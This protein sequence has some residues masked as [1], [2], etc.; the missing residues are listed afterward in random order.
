MY[1]TFLAC[2]RRL[3]KPDLGKPSRTVWSYGSAHGEDY[4]SFWWIVI[5]TPRGCNW[6]SN[7][8]WKVKEEDKSP[9]R[10]RRSGKS[11]SKNPGRGEIGCS[12][13]NCRA[14]CRFYRRKKISARWT[15]DWFH[16]WKEGQR[17]FGRWRV[18]HRQQ[19]DITGKRFWRHSGKEHDG[20]LA[21]EQNEL[22]FRQ[23]SPIDDELRNQEELIFEKLSHWSQDKQGKSQAMPHEADALDWSL[24]SLRSA[25]TSVE[26]TLEVKHEI[27]IY[28]RPKCLSV[29]RNQVVAEEVKNMLDA[30]VVAPATSVWS[31]LMVKTTK[32]DENPILCI[33]YR[34]LCQWTKADQCPP[35]NYEDVFYNRPGC[36]LFMKLDLFGGYWQ[37]LSA[38]PELDAAVHQEQ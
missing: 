21:D 1:N 19:L 26:R 11:L 25:A 38:K 7:D 16:E 8:P 10:G 29:R 36:Q 4:H 17:L 28:H 5:Q 12:E 24:N 23:E 27:P 30:I 32:K 15:L 35:P 33:A 3:A 18:D 34:L 22:K 6:C 37:M 13:Q 31:V 14:L 2:Y 20:C 9:C